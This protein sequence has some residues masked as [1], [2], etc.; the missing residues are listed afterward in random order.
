MKE[1]AITLTYDCNW[2]CPYCAVRNVYDRR[3]TTKEDVLRK[4]DLI[5]N[6]SSVTFFGGEPGL[7]DKDDLLLYIR[8]LTLKFCDLELETNGTFIKKYP[9]LLKYF[10]EVRYHCSSDLDEG[11]IQKIVPIGNEVY[12]YLIVVHDGN[13]NKLKSFL[14]LNNDIIFDV[15][16]AT[17]PYEKTGPTLSRE[18]KNYIITHFFRSMS[19]ESLGWLLHGRNYDNKI[20]LM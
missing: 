10:K 2:H 8:A 13:F 7:V 17:Y 4:I 5:E 1:Y 19:K 3:Q 9:E 12:R 6:G 20:Y 15:I 16:E 14:E 11:K 18:N